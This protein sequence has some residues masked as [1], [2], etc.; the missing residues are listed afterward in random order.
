MTNLAR[1]ERRRVSTK[2]GTDESPLSWQHRVTSR[3]FPGAQ[4]T[5]GAIPAELAWLRADPAARRLGLAPDAAEGAGA[6][7]GHRRVPREVRRRPAQVQ[8]PLLDAG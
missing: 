4:W 3:A 6:D 7:W 8:V 2:T 5:H 1:L